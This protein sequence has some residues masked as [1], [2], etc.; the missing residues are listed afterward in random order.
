MAAQRIT[1]WPVIR[2]A[3]A[4]VLSNIMDVCLSRDILK[5]GPTTILKVGRFL[6]NGL[7]SDLVSRQMEHI[8]FN[9]LILAIA[10]DKDRQAFVTLFEHYGPRLKAFMIKRGLDA[11]SAEDVAQEAMARVWRRATTF[12]PGRSDASAW[13]FSIARNLGVDLFRRKLRSGIAVE[14]PDDLEDPSR[15]DEVLLDGE[16]KERV[17]AALASLPR[18]QLQLVRL[19]FFEDK[20]HSEIA[21]LLDIPLGTVKSRLRL[22]YGKLRPLLGDLK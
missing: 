6:P 1:V 16:Q 21:S 22:A 8:D 11:Q 12:D 9:H 7:N 18:E 14:V 2:H 4:A 5:Q 10:L 3:G 20:P 13:I 15:A 17:A 19:A